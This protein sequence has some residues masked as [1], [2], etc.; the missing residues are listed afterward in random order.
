MVR[1]GGEV[2]GAC[3]GG[4]GTGCAGS[5]CFGVEVGVA[6]DWCVVGG[7]D[8]AVGG[9]G[10]RGGPG[11][12]S[13]VRTCGFGAVPS[14]ERRSEVSDGYAEGFALQVLWDDALNRDPRALLA[15]AAPRPW[16]EADG[17]VYWAT[18]ADADLIVAAVNEYEALLDVAEAASGMMW[19]VIRH[20]GSGAFAMEEQLRSALTRLD[21]IRD[22]K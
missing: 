15:A 2:G 18:D 5:G 4:S 14:H 16:K 6:D 13:G 8:G 21:A 17:T 22:A 9:R 20:P 19:T 12:C 7:C 3:G 10:T 1:L 11:C